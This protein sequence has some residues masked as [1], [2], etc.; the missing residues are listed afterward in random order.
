[1]I[2]V[3]RHNIRGADKQEAKNLQNIQL[4]SNCRVHCKLVTFLEVCFLEPE[5]ATNSTSL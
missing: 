2:R 5:K 1:M 4:P 3:Q